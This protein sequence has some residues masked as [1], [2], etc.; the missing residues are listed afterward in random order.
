MFARASVSLGL[1]RRA[2]RYWVIAERSKFLPASTSG[3]ALDVVG[4]V[5]AGC[6]GA[7]GR[8]VSD[9]GGFSLI[10]ASL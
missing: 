2:L 4:I 3:E 8:G 5:A 1:M 9:V 10:K 7:S 6:C